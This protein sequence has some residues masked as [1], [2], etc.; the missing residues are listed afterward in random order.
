MARAL[1][2]E[3]K[4]D[5]GSMLSADQDSA[6][7]IWSW[8]QLCQTLAY[9]HGQEYKGPHLVK[10]TPDVIVLAKPSK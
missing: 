3:I 10:T 7:M 9:V 6:N 4:F 2:I 5:D 8:F 1:S